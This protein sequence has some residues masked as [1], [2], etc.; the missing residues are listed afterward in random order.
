ME[1]DHLVCAATTDP[2]FV[3]SAVAS[4]TPLL[5]AVGVAHSVI[6]LELPYL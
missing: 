1:A 3:H 5:G 4:T 6:Q 2:F